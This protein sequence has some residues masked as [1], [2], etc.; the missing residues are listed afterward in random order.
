MLGIEIELFC[1]RGKGAR[2]LGELDNACRVSR[3]K[4]RDRAVDLF[5][6]TQQPLC[7]RK[8]RENGTVRL[9]KLVRDAGGQ[10]NQP[11]TVAGQL[12][13]PFDFFF[14][15]CNKVRGFDFRNLMTKKIEL[16]LARRL[17]GVQRR[18]L[19]EQ[20]LQ[21][22]VMLSIFAKLCF[23]A[24]ERIEQAQLCLGRE[25]RL[26]I[27]RPVEIDKFVAEIFQD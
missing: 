16:L 24:R 18:L 14:F 25:Q 6:L 13:A 22:P 17:S 19:G 27:V 12:V 4:L 23:N 20:R 11:F 7:F 10:L 9:R 1:V 26:V 2:N 15:A 3:R 21:L 5:Q 8:L